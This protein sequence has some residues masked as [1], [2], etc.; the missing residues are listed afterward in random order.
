[1]FQWPFQEPKLEVPAIYK[2]YVLG[3]CKGISPEKYG[4]IWCSTSILG[5]WNS[6]WR[7]VIRNHVFFRSKLFRWEITHS[8]GDLPVQVRL[9]IPNNMS[10]FK[11]GEHSE[12][13]NSK[14][15]HDNY[16]DIII[17]N[18]CYFWI[19]KPHPNSNLDYYHVS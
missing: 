2:A 6:Q 16:H 13:S 7:M 8:R 11:S 3:L 14:R 17:N 4:L 19:I 1:M 12:N 15:E 5:S 9:P 10:L 18:Y